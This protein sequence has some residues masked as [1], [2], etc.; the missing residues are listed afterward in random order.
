MSLGATGRDIRRMV[1]RQACAPVLAGTALGVVAACRAEP[2]IRE[3]LY[4]VQGRDPRAYAIVA[5]LLLATAAL[6]VWLPARRAGRVDSAV[7]LRAQ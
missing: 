5:A 6:A 4:E 7:V 1:V 2:F 3:F